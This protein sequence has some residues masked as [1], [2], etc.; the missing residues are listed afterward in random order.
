MFFNVD[1][2]AKSVTIAALAGRKLD[3]H[4]IHRKSDSDTLA[5]TA[6]YNRATGGFTIPPRTTVVF[7]EKGHDHDD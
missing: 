2:V 5:R 7:V 3:V 1:K 4:K 6:S